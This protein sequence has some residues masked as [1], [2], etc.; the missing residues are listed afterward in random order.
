MPVQYLSSPSLPLPAAAAAPSVNSSGVVWGNSSWVELTA[1]LGSDSLLLSITP[2]THDTNNAQ[3]EADIGVGSAGSEVVVCTVKGRSAPVLSD[4]GDEVIFNLPIPIDAL[5]SGSRV[6]ARIRTNI[7]TVQT[8]R[9]CATYAEKPIVGSVLTTANPVKV[10]PSAANQTSTTAS[11][12]AWANGAWAQVTA[13]TAAAIILVGVSTSGGLRWEMD[14]GTGA[15][16]SEVVQTT[17]RCNQ[18]ASVDGLRHSLIMFPIPLD[19]IGSGVRVAVRSR[20]GFS[21]VSGR[22][23]RIGLMYIEKPL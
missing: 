13:S 11:T 20:Y 1:S 21:E 19:V 14:I 18:G 16:G 15:A 9:I 3:F 8:W 10:L 23:L 17:I 6:A 5:P 22:T 12:T 7:T 2:Y 4:A